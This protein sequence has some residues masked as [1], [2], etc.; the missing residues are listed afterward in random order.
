MKIV[1]S[2][3]VI[4]ANG[5]KSVRNGSSS[6]GHTSQVSAANI[7]DIGRGI[8]VADVCWGIS[9]ADVNKLVK[10]PAL[11]TVAVKQLP[12]LNPGPT[13]TPTP[14]TTSIASS[15][16]RFD[17]KDSESR[18]SHLPTTLNSAPLSGVYSSASDPVL[19]P[20]LNPRNPGVVGAIKRETGSQ[21]SATEFIGS[22]LERKLNTGQDGRN[23]SQADTGTANRTSQG[24]EKSQ[25]SKPSRMSSLS[26]DDK[27]IAIS[28]QD[29]WLTHQVDGPSKGTFDSFLVVLF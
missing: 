4:P 8:S 10:S 19:L 3:S 2:S 11:P 21:R 7:V 14:T 22:S 18:S 17:G 6:S 15:G 26:N 13:P 9:V 27:S 25:N 29:G 12:N 20:S 16:A 1:H 24:V 23:N 28:E 5:P